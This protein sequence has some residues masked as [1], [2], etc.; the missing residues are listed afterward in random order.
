MNQ[1]KWDLKRVYYPFHLVKSERPCNLENLR[2]YP[3]SGV[4]KKWGWEGPACVVAKRERKP[5]Q[6][7]AIP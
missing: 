2:I 4:V 5:R 7:R 1:D 6:Q 3:L